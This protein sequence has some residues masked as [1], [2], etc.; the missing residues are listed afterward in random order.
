M[1]MKS[2]VS[3]NID[4]IGYENGALR[5]QF[6]NGRT[7]EYTGPKV[8]EYHDG[9]MKAESVGKYFIAN[10]RFCPRTK[11]ELVSTQTEAI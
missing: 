1:H 6:R 2:V 5:I 8:P 10:I 11:S 9:L 4:S 7:H 3:S